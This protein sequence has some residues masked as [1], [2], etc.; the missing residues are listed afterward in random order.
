MLEKYDDLFWDNLLNSY[1][2][3]LD[4]E[5]EDVQINDHIYEYEVYYQLNK[6]NVKDDVIEIIRKSFS[7]KEIIES[8]CTSFEKFSGKCNIDHKFLSETLKL[9]H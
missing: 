2:L 7:Y 4:E 5:K 1:K 3:K 8:D 6:H 9:F